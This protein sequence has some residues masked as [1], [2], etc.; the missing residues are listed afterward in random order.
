MGDDGLCLEKPKAGNTDT[1]HFRMFVAVLMWPGF[2]YVVGGS[3]AQKCDG[4][5]K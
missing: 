4:S 3:S 2:L 1:Q 5:K